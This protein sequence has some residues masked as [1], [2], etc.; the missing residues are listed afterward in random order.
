MTVELLFL[1]IILSCHVQGQCEGSSY[2]GCLDAAECCDV[3][4]R[5]EYNKVMYDDILA[6]QRARAVRYGIDGA[7]LKLTNPLFEIPSQDAVWV[8]C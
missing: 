1:R 2:T 8:W 3:A 5:N 7:P 6:K 4:A